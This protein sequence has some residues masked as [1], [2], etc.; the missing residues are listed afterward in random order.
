MV[1]GHSLVDKAGGMYSFGGYDGTNTYG[2]RKWGDG[3]V[4]VETSERPANRVFQSMT[5]MGE[6]EL[7]LS[8]GSSADGDCVFEDTWMYNISSAS[9]HWL[10]GPK[11]CTELERPAEFSWLTFAA[12][13]LGSVSISSVSL[14][15]LRMYE[16]KFYFAKGPWVQDP[17][18]EMNSNSA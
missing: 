8:G 4:D 11:E 10:H 6:H 13:L 5:A 18:I 3:W 16:D 15:V 1:F 9:W 12:S 17:E 7:W 2:L 14:V